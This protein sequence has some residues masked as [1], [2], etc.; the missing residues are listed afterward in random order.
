LLADNENIR[1]GIATMTTSTPDRY[2]LAETTVRRIGY[3]AMQLAAGDGFQPRDRDEALAVLRE[4]V[5]QAWTTST[6]PST[7]GPA[8]S[9]S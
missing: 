7:T 5:T 9:M 1:E 3:G 6:P 2:V 4:A 8:L